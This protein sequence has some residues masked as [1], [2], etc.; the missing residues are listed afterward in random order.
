MTA[1]VPAAETADAVRLVEFGGR[2]DLAAQ[3]LIELEEKHKG[4]RNY[5]RSHGGFDG[6]VKDMRKQFKFMGE[7]GCYYFLWVV[8][9]DV[10][11]YEDWCKSRGRTP[12]PHDH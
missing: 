3:R 4:F 9:E 10:P 1:A 5:L 11:E 2:V 7:T 8:N 6:T 12:Y